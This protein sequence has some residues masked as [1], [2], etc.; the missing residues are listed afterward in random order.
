MTVDKAVP[1]Q[2]KPQTTALPQKKYRTRAVTN[3]GSSGYKLLLN[4]KLFQQIPPDM[5]EAVLAESFVKRAPKGQVIISPGEENHNL[6]LLVS[7]LLNVNLD[8]ADS[9]LNLPIE[10][11]ECVGEMSIIEGGLTSAFVVA[12]KDS[13]LIVIPENVFWDKFIH[14]PGGVKNLLQVLSARM[15]K[16]NELVLQSLEEKL[17]Y[18]HLQKELETA[19]KIQAS[20]LPTNIPLLPDHPQA[21]V[22]AFIKP[23][24][25][26]GGDFYDA[27]ALDKEHICIA[28]GDVSGKG[29][30]AALFMVRVL[31]LLRMSL[32]KDHHNFESVVPAVN[33]MLCQNNEECMFATLFVG[34]L[35]VTTGKL[36][37]VNGGHNAPFFS[38][39]G[40]PFSLLEMPKG[41]LV[42]VHEGAKYRVGELNFKPGDTLVLYT[43]G[44]TEAENPHKE[45]F[46]KERAC[47]TLQ[48]VSRDKDITLIVKQ[49]EEAILKF[50]KG[51]PQ[52]DDITMLALRY[53][54]E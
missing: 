6:Y 40:S 15:R 3:D 51:Q 52:S 9:Q 22:C 42:G 35:N 16:D 44:V 39:G 37:Y 25:E 21:D 47:K 14:T 29:M 5:V 19:G 26:V 34:I 24:K 46:T 18:E 4:H 8:T 11:G 30:P 10:P 48:A 1:K 31:T 23:A 13:K 17:R 12:Q 20:L 49:M 7:G 33:Q 41:I 45:L 53:K 36:T 50:A 38:T 28:I 2:L 43:D 27:F 54:I 32:L